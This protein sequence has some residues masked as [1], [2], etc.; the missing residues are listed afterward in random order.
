MLGNANAAL[1]AIRRASEASNAAGLLDPGLD[2]I[3]A[4]Y[5]G[6]HSGALSSDEERKSPVTP[7]GSASSTVDSSKSRSGCE[8]TAAGASRSDD[9]YDEKPELVT[10]LPPCRPSAVD[11]GLEFSVVGHDIATSALDLRYPDHAETIRR[12][13][14]IRKQLDTGRDCLG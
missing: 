1:R 6:T 2:P 7:V 4:V 13:A 3:A 9:R 12:E 14:A 10:A 8:T 11:V 5:A